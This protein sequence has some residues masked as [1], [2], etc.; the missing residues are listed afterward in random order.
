MSQRKAAQ[1]ILQRWI[2]QPYWRIQR[3]LTLGAQGVIVDE[4][5]RV[6]LV[7]HTY[8]PGWCFPGGGVEKGE[9]VL[10]ALTREL[11]EECG[12]AID[13]PPELFGIYSNHT[14]FANDHVAL[15]VVRHWHRTHIPKP[16]S[17]IAAQDFFARDPLPDDC[18]HGT[19][20]RLAE[21]FDS[22]PRDEHW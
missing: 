4:A 1:M 14:R 10:T 22:A 21:I 3:P 20:K 16:N 9:T 12:V 13:G 6:L 17:E 18:A 15:F 8:R 7:K 11:H 5:G 2:L 19:A